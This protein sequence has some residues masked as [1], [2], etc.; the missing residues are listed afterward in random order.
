MPLIGSIIFNAF[1]YLSLIPITTIIISLY[2]FISTKHLQR[3]GAMWIKVVLNALKILCGISWKVEGIK[4]IPNTP[5]IVV[6]NHQGQW[7]SFFLQTLFIPSTSIIK[8]E[9]LLIPLFGWALR[10]MKPITLNRL[11][12]V[13]SLKKVI[14]KGVIKLKNGFSIILFPEG[15]R[16]SPERGI[17]PFARSCGLLSVKSGFPVLP[18]CH[19]SGK[20]WKNKKFIKSPGKV[21]LRIGEP[22]LGKDPKVITNDAYN[23][24]KNNYEE[25]N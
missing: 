15:T 5:C 6:S 25:I 13:S 22:I 10:C 17:Q 12:R 9:L 4:N 14:K 7:E 3:L 2:F 11:N 19:N 18:I 16:I 1:F 20:Y 24:V 23:W 21:V 8:K